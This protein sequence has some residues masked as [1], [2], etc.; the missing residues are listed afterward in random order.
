MDGSQKYQGIGKVNSKPIYKNNMR[1]LQIAVDQRI[2]EIN[3]KCKR[4]ANENLIT[5]F[6]TGPHLFIDF[7]C[8]Q[9]NDLAGRLGYNDWSG[10]FTLS[11]IPSDIQSCNCTYKL[12]AAIEYIGGTNKNDIRHY[13]AH[14]RRV[15]SRKL[16]DICMII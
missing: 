3:K 15:T 9:W 8:L 2:Q 4:C 16:G 14:C 10:M 1:G 6:T 11:E 13:I 7:E 12:V 5:N